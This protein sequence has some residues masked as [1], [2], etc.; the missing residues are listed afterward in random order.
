MDKTKE[1]YR[2]TEVNKINRSVI[3]GQQHK[4]PPCQPTTDTKVIVNGPLEICAPF[5]YL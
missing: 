3:H 2:H 5:G 4:Q 1:R